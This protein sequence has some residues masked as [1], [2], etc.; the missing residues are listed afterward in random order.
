MACL[1]HD[2]GHPPFGHNGE[3]AL[4]RICA[5][6]GGFEGNAQT[7]RLLTR[8]EPKRCPR[9]RVPCGPEP[10]ARVPRRGDEVPVGARRRPRPP[11]KFG[12]YE[13]DLPV[14][15]WMRTGA[16]PAV[17]CFE[18]QVMDWSDDVAYSVHDLEDA[19]ASDWMDLASCGPGRD[20][21][22]PRGRRATYAPDLSRRPRSPTHWTGSS[23]RGHPV[24]LRRLSER[25]S[26]P[27]R[28]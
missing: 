7:L 20:A 8:L 28:T 18:A 21:R 22:C 14:F 17:R 12:V 25:T 15:E 2:L 9:R 4:D 5:D 3:M 6:I 19:I 10:D 16:E 24:G 27:S 1:A 11:P 13:D 23:H 26:P